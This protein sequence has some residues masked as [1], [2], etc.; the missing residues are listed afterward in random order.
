MRLQRGGRDSPEGSRIY[1]LKDLRVYP[2]MAPYPLPQA[3]H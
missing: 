1:S 2:P 3:R